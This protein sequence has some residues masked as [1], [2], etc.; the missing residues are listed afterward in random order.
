MCGNCYFD[1]ALCRREGWTWAAMEV[2]Y[3][4]RKKSRPRC[5]FLECFFVVSY[6]TMSTIL[7]FWPSQHV[8]G[9]NQ[10][11]LFVFYVQ[12]LIVVLVEYV[13]W[14]SIFHQSRFSFNRKLTNRRPAGTSS[15][16]SAHGGGWMRSRFCSCWLYGVHLLGLGPATL[17]LEQ[18]V[19]LAGDQ[20]VDMFPVIINSSGLIY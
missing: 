12:L 8:A 10:S 13:A 4:V 6:R 7:F 9:E 1:R 19:F 18:Y 15:F 20:I 17:S 16:N 11:V 3:C 5:W 14:R 2:D